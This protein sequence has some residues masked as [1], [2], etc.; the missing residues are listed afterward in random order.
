MAKTQIKN[1]V[2]KPGIGRDDNLYPNAY[3]LLVDNKEFIQKE[4]TQYITDRIANAAQY[5][6]TDATY[7]PATGDMTI[8]IGTHTFNVGDAIMIDTHGITFTCEL[9]GNASLHPYPRPVGVPNETG[10]DPYYNKPIII[11]ATTATTV[12]V[13]VGISSDTST[14]TFYSAKTNAVKD[15]FFNYQNTSQAK[16]E[17]DIGLI[18]DAYKYDIRYGGNSKTYKYVNYYWDNGVAQVDGD[19]GPE[20]AAHAFIQRLITDYIFTNTTWTPQNVQGVSQTIGSATGE[21]G[22][23]SRIDELSTVVINVIHN[24]T[25]SLPVFEDTG[26]GQISIQGRYDID[27]LL[28]ITDSTENQIIYNFADPTLGGEIELVTRGDSENF[29]SYLQTTDAVTIVSL[30]YNTSAHPST[31]ELQIFVEKIENGKSI[32]TVRPYDFGTDAIERMRIA[33]PLSMLDADFEYGLQPTKWSA[34]AMMRGYPSVYEIPGTDADVLSITTDASAGT[35]GIGASLITVETVAPHGFQDGTPITIKALEN[36]VTGAARA[37]GSFVI[38]SVP[39]DRTFTY[40]AKSKVGISNGEVLSTNYTQLREAGFYTGAGITNAD[41]QVVSNGSAGTMTA[42]LQVPAG[43]NTIPYDGNSPEIG[44]PLNGTG[45]QTG[46]QVTNFIDNSNGGGEYLTLDISENQQPGDTEITVTSVSGIVQN[47]AVDRGDGQAVFINNIVGNTLE[48][49]GAL[50]APITSNTKTYTGLLPNT[51]PVDGVAAQFDITRSGGAYS[52]DQISVPGSFYKIGDRLKV[53]GPQLGGA[54]PANDCTIYIDGVNANGGVTSATLSGTAIGSVAS[55][56]DVPGLHLGGNGFGL[57]LDV[58]L[59]NNVF[60]VA[61]ASTDASQDYI[62]YEQVRILGS[63]FGGTDGV[64]DA[65]VTITSV[66]GTGNVTGLSISGTAPNADV[67]YPNVTYTATGANTTATLDIRRVGTVYEAIVAPVAAGSGYSINDTLVVDGAALGGAST[68]N[69]ATVTVDN[70]DGSGAITAVSVA[71]VAVNEETITTGLFNTISPSGA[72]FDV[73]L[74]AT[75]YT[76][77]LASAG[78]NYAVNQELYIRG[79]LIGGETPTN[80]ITIT[81]T[82]VGASGDITTFTFT[83]T[84]NN[85]TLSYTNLSPIAEIPQGTGAVF[86]VTRSNGTY[87][88]I[89]LQNGGSNY[90]LGNTLSIPG[91]QLDGQVQNEIVFFVTGVSGGAITSVNTTFTSAEPGTNLALICTMTMSELT[92]ATIPIGSTVDFSELA[93]LEATFGTPHGIV[94]GNSFIITVTSDDGSN[95]HSL[96]AGAFLATNIPSTTK[97]RF[98]ARTAGTISTSATDVIAGT[99]YTRPDSFFIHRPFDG[100]VQ[101]GTGGPQHGAQAIR[102]SKKYIRYQSGK[103]IMYTTGALFAPSYDLKSVSAEGTEV[104]NLI[105]ITTDDNDH[106]VQAGGVIRLLGIETS[107]YNS[108][109]QSVTPPDYD[110]TVQEV[111]NERTFKVRALR[112]LGDTTEYLTATNI[113]DYPIVQVF[114]D[115]ILGTN[116]SD[117]HDFF[118]NETAYDGYSW[119]DFN[120]SGSVTA[121]DK[122][123][124]TNYLQGI[125]QATDLNNRV[126]IALDELKARR[127]VGTVEDTVPVMEQEAV[128]GFGAQMSVVSWH[129]ATVRSGIFD[130]QNGIFW[131][132]DGTQISVVQRT[133]TLQIAGTVAV[134]SDSNTLIGSGTRFRDQLKAGDRVI[135]RG[136][137]HVVSHVVSQ[138]EINVTP[139][140]R[141]V[142]DIS[143]A[144]MM[145]ITDKKTK[146]SDFNLDRLDGTGP[147]GY[148]IDIA[149]MQMIGIQYSWYGAGFIDFMLRGS[150]GNFVFCHRMR[151]SN[152]NTEAFM[153]SGNLPVRYEVTNEGPPGKL[154]AAIDNTQTTIP[155]EDS[156]FFPTNGTVYID[157]EIISFT[158]NDKTTN[159][160]TGCTRGTTLTNFQAGAERTYSAG[161]ALSHVNKTGVVLIS[162]TITPLIS[163]WGS[164]FLT[165]GGFDEDRGYIFSYSE[166]GIEASTTKQ[167]AFM[168]RLAPSV[169]NA[170]V[171]DLGERELLN[172]AQLL[173]QGL[174]ITSDGSDSS[175][176]TVTGG[177]VIEG[178]LNPQNYPTNPSDVG[179]TGLSSVA[180][181]GQPSFA[182]VASGGSVKWTTGQAATNT[183]GTQ[184][185][186]LTATLD[187]GIYRSN[188]RSNYLW[189]NATD[190]RNTFGTTSLA[191]VSGLEVDSNTGNIRNG[192]TINGGFIA[193][194]GDYGYFILSDRL[195]G[196]INQNQANDLTVTLDATLNNRNFAYL[197]SASYLASGIA[198]GTTVTQ[199]GGTV[200]FPANTTV[201]SIAQRSFAGTTYYEVTFN[202]AFSGTLQP[203]T[204]TIQ[205]EFSQPPYAQPGETVFSFIAVPGERS[206][207][208]FSELKELTNTTLGGRGT[209]P[210]GPD[211]L[212]INVYKVS[213]AATNANLILK[214]GEAQA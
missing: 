170:I 144:K 40:Y 133:G 201:N 68:T 151:N 98:N 81:V 22:A 131:E 14:H 186:N 190:Y 55:F 128:I 1:Y 3:S 49:S 12:T 116:T 42:Q 135:I 157:N 195:T 160:L 33:P 150:D 37:E 64:E 62:A 176:N 104:G 197:T 171:G 75:V 5:T 192:T 136:M 168:I 112:R 23:L 189:V 11:T 180:Q 17:R 35:N 213:G 93:T 29:P 45:I 156:S 79:N 122:L 59:S 9:D 72:L 115:I 162:N 188:R 34:I 205:F 143:G 91:N 24:G 90:E 63:E 88:N 100:G 196:N 164:A 25:S 89:T 177:I 36:S 107:G 120:G 152:V 58:T 101:L 78:S 28:L 204:G 119:G 85:G 46:A 109:L 53:L 2:F 102:Q 184:I 18:I 84:G 185:S 163:H 165:D 27:E 208:D 61:L 183:T 105:T 97:L 67:V 57:V 54:T 153:R 142:S 203:S 129:G 148:D 13:N 173:L 114:D 155:L 44:S 118:I 70:V 137:T 94:P 96:A 132:Y 43:V 8:T 200:T 140:F 191:P 19:R 31:D 74:N 106:G 178:I 26:V 71:G 66:G 65:L 39:T 149:K 86:D 134:S 198:N 181:G 154:A 141:G 138:T 174:E 80:D 60:S 83:G 21:A 77:T 92:T 161:G 113:A 209:F 127:N 214:W 73:D 167:T 69:N 47:L 108:G 56:T 146:Q 111:V 207:A 172:R 16:C 7:I 206:T 38:V 82:G 4:G 30:D 194:T 202:N 95:N 166:T 121:D 179:W 51:E 110:Y 169:S 158:G 147:S 103:G 182:Q 175:G 187:T 159:T 123:A 124:L 6:P 48:L 76:V 99:F 52:L 50:T 20:L 210:N 41:F 212:A 10:H 145:L 125:N 117:I 211:V 32:Q 126:K 130:D 193:D 15:V 87:S 199:T 139:D